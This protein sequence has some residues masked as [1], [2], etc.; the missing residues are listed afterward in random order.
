MNRWVPALV[1]FLAVPT[2]I[3]FWTEATLARG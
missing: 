1:A 2:F 3:A